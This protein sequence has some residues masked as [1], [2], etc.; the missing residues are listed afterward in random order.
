MLVRL[1]NFLI[2]HLF[3]LSHF[4]VAGDTSIEDG[5]KNKIAQRYES[6]KHYRDSGKI[7]IK[8]YKDKQDL[9]RTRHTTFA[10]EFTR[11]DHFKLEWIDTIREVR[12]NFRSTISKNGTD[13]IY[14]KQLKDSEKKVKKFDSL[15]RVLVQA[16]GTSSLT[17]TIVPMLFF[18]DMAA[19]ILSNSDNDNDNIRL[20]DEDILF[21]EKMHVYEFYYEHTSSKKIWVESDSYTIRK[22]EW[23]NEDGES[24]LRFHNVITYDEVI[25]GKPQITQASSW[26]CSIPLI[27]SYLCN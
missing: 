15:Y 12:G 5:I 11:P 10:T 24:G 21:G 19:P 22:V 18:E 8:H 16:A 1:V 17:S 7:I 14:E 26:Y 6:I 4:C 2:I 25:I 20:I 23:W 9:L 13:I 3:L 27:F